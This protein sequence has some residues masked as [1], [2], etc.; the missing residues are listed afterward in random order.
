MA[1]PLPTPWSG[2]ADWT[3]PVLLAICGAFGLAAAAAVLTPAW[4]W[5]PLAIVAITASGVLAFRHIVAVCVAWLM[6]AGATLEMT[7]GDIVGPGA[8]QGTIAAVKAAELGLALLC[9]LRYGFYP[10]VFNPG[11]AFVAMFIAGLAHGLHPELTPMGSLRSL[12]GSVA[13]FAFAFSRLSPGWGGTMVRATVLILLA[14]VAGGVV[15]HLAGLH[16][17]FIDSFGVRLAGLGEPAVLAG[18]CLAAIYACLIELYRDG[19]SRWLLLLATNFLILVLTGAR[20][21]LACAVAVTGLTLGFVRSAAFPRQRRI[22]TLLLAACLL[23]LLAVLAPELPMV[24]LFHI[25]NDEATNLSGRGLL[26]PPFEQAAAASPWFGWGV[27]AGNAIIPPDSEVAWTIGNWVAHNEYLRI[28]VEGGQ[29]GRALLIGMLVLWVA[30]HTRGLCRTDKVIIRLAFAGFAVQAYTD[31]VLIAATAGVFF[32][33]VTAV[34]ARGRSGGGTFA[35]GPR[36]Q[37]REAE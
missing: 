5:A 1:I 36:Q 9:V 13:P 17:V 32:T 11:L 30:R 4:Y 8:Y 14:S 22:L 19:R 33:F 34:F 21:P 18:F 20:S 24:R 28:S 12:L 23:P 15:F 27:G 3:H 29:L 6:I 16:P 35:A 31:N 7:L 2:Q 37:A 25:W 26:W 10:D